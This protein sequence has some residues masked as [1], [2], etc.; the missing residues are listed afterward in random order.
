M[1]FFK[2]NTEEIDALKSKNI[3]L[4]EE[5]ERLKFELENEKNKVVDVVDDRQ[6]AM[7]KII[8][9][10][11]KSY[12][13]GVGFVQAIMEANLEA[14]ET[15]NTVNK[16]TGTI[17]T[18]VQSGGESIN[19][20][21]NKIIEEA[22]NLDNGANG[23]ND[24]V[25]SISDVINLIKDISDQTNLLALNAA[26]EAA[27]AGEH[28]RG[29]AVVA[30]EVRKLAERTQKATSEV[31][32]SITQLKQNTSEIQEIAQLFRTTTT[33]I[34]EALESFFEELS[35]V[36]SNTQKTANTTTNI[37]NEIGIGNGKLDHIL[38]KLLAYNA[39]IEDDSP[40]IGDSN[41]CRFGKWLSV[42]KEFIKDDSKTLNSLGSHHDIVHQKLSIAIELWKNEKYEEAVETMTSVEYSSETAFE[43]LYESFVNHRI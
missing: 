14:L 11:L 28:G 15:S 24:S 23:L 1:S 9:I 40:T 39:F 13:S 21:I 38:M 33:D 35:S 26:I 31:E 27:R 6:V 19:H 37:S 43:E 7:M 25:S 22:L 12:K 30:D 42:N 29:F 5:C 16:E 20:S 36:I 3:A 32:I 4:E 8:Q 18:S 41:S 10:L 2:K 17:I 34:S